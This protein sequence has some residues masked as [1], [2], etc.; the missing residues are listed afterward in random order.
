VR[1]RLEK[2]LVTFFTATESPESIALAALS[3]STL[4]T[5][6]RTPERIMKRRGEFDGGVP[7]ETISALAEFPGDTEFA[8][9]PELLVHDLEE[10]VSRVSHVA[11]REDRALEES[12]ETS[13]QGLQCHARPDNDRPGEAT[14]YIPSD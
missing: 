13:Q 8:V 7:D 12:A 10:R 1:I 2:M 14:D 6:Q 11:N 5:E 3:E 9:D 4:A